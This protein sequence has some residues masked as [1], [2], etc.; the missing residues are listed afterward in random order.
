MCNQPY[1]NY[2]HIEKLWL[3]QEAFTVLLWAQVTLKIIHLKKSETDRSKE[4]MRWLSHIMV[5]LTTFVC[6]ALLPVFVLRAAWYDFKN[7]WWYNTLMWAYHVVM[8]PWFPMFATTVIVFG[9]KL[10]KLLNETMDVFD[11]S[12][13]KQTASGNG[14]LGTANYSQNRVSTYA[15]L[16]SD[17]RKAKFQSAI[18]KI[19]IVSI[20]VCGDKLY[21]LPVA[22]CS[23][24]QRLRSTAE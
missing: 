20:L 22:F 10:T 21:Q 8:L 18:R 17:S 12:S 3:S 2:P 1:P 13:S 11:N 9:F 4:L 19:K 24:T 7:P 5:G 16:R 6:V 14:V 23:A 15:Q